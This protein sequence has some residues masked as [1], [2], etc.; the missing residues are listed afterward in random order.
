[1]FAAMMERTLDT[2]EKYGTAALVI[3]LGLRFATML[4]YS[5]QLAQ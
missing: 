4:Y 2:L 5:F 1:M 3:Y